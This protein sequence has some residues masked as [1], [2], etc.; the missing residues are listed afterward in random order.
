MAKAVQAGKTLKYSPQSP[1]LTTAL[2]RAR[3]TSRVLVRQTQADRQSKK[4]NPG[5]KEKRVCFCMPRTDTCIFRSEQIP[6]TVRL[7]IKS[8]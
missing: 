7:A 3:Q 2:L 8:S 6:P 1:N 5:S 4:P